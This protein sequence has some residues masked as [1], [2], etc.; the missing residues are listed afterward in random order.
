MVLPRHYPCDLYC[1]CRLDRVAPWRD[2]QGSA[3]GN[4][5]PVANNNAY[6]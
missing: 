1:D 2:A 6:H 5:K 3:T 4:G